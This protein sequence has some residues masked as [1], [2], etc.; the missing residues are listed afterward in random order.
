MIEYVDKIDVS[1]QHLLGIIND[2]LDMS[3]IE[4]GKTV[5]SYSDFSILE[6]MQEI[7]T[8]FCPQTEEKHQSLVIHHE[9]I[10]HE[11]VNSD[12]VHL[13]QIFSNLLSNAVKYTQ[14]GGKIQFLVEECETKSSAYAKYHFAVIDN[15][16]GMSED[17]KDKIF[18]TFTR[19]ESSLTNKI[20]G[21]G[22]G[23]AITKNL[24]EAMGGTIDVDSELGLGSCFEVFM[25]LKIAEE[26]VSS[27]LQVEE[28]ETY[29]DIMKG[30]RFLC[31]EDNELN[32]E[33]LTELLK[34]KGAECTV[35]ENGERILET[36][37]R[38]APGDYDMILMD[39]QMPVMNGYEA[40]KA[41]R[42]SSHEQA[43]TIPIIAMTANAFSDDIHHSL[44][45]GMNAHISKPVEMKV[46]E[47]TI[48]SIK[49]GGGLKRRLLNN[50]DEI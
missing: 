39:V 14:K 49:F 36:F 19:E 26:S 9:N 17:F 37:E 2:V 34:I 1:A 38:S 41:I 20:Q 7:Q 46:L 40:T 18:D 4:A 30:M 6:F 25:D 21:T 15:G 5:F 10:V 28:S 16:V 50:K 12:Y 48:S 13:M 44:T 43:K 8:M 45:V 33:I 47:K 27:A 31:A 3:K 23:M 11:W 29:D 24:I 32:A 42:K 35:C 22:L